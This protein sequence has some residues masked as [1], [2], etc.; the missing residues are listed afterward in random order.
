MKIPDPLFLLARGYVIASVKYYAS[1][2]EVLCLNAVLCLFWFFIRFLGFQIASFLPRK[3]RKK[4][5]KELFS[6]RH[7]EYIIFG[8][9]CAAS[10]LNGRIFYFTLFFFLNRI[11]ISLLLLDYVDKAMDKWLVAKGYLNHQESE[12]HN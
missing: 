10:S 3:E 9:D 8:P 11:V 5:T 12:I 4:S 1:W 7:Y 2:T 6:S